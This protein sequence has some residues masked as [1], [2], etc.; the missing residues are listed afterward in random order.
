MLA[1]M[2]LMGMTACGSERRSGGSSVSKLNSSESSS[3]SGQDTEK[4]SGKDDGKDDGNGLDSGKK[5]G[6]ETGK[7]GKEA[8]INDFKDVTLPEDSILLIYFRSNYAWGK[9]ESGKFVDSKG[10]VYS[11]CFSSDDYCLAAAHELSF[12]EKLDIVRTYDKPVSNIDEDMLKTIYGLGSR[13]DKNAGYEEEFTMCDYGQD[14][15]YFVPEGSDEP[16][17]IYSYGDVTLTPKDKNAYAL[18]KYA[19][20]IVSAAIRLNTTREND[21]RI[22]FGDT[23]HIADL[24][25]S[26]G[27]YEFMN[28]KCR[29][30]KGGVYM[31]VTDNKQ[32]V[33]DF[34]ANLGFGEEQVK[35]FFENIYEPNQDEMLYFIE[36]Y[37]DGQLGPDNN[38]CGML[39]K[40]GHY[41]LIPSPHNKKRGEVG[42]DALDYYC[43]IIGY[44]LSGQKL[45]DLAVDGVFGEYWTVI[46]SAE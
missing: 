32:V 11:F 25:D 14:S 22:L 3:E 28:S 36:L 17:K 41:T 9:H 10:D 12:L 1:L 30:A 23:I 26:G 4:N 19:D 44:P 33:K 37:I 20:T 34:A 46:D 38:T 15:I 2:M 31:A 6:K 29:D 27:N 40:D 42:C 39:I 16:L 5:D 35:E 21:T 7:D 18:E 43:H 45:D 13:I 24:H 8:N